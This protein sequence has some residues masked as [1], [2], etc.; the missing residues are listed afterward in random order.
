MRLT[1]RLFYWTDESTD[2]LLDLPSTRL[3][4]DYTLYLYPSN[5]F[6]SEYDNQNAIVFTAILAA[7]FLATGIIFFVFVVLVQQ[8]Q[9]KVVATANKTNAI[10]QSLFPGN[11]RERILED[12]EEQ[13][14]RQTDI[15]VPKNVSKFV[16]RKKEQESSYIEDAANRGDSNLVFGSKPIADLFPEATI[17]F[18][19][20]VGF[21]AWS[22]VREPSAVF[23][24]LEILYHRSA[25]CGCTMRN[26]TQG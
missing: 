12:A 20:L 15:L 2:T 18:A 7:V 25:D 24:L 19:D 23:T 9:K 16:K 11:V 3:R 10:V 4:S 17:M 8:R 13:E 5:E 21:T 1:K 22:S 6:R 26:P 14:K